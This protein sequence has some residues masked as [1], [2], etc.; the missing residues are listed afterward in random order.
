MSRGEN[1]GLATSGRTTPV[2]GNVSIVTFVAKTGGAAL[3]LIAKSDTA[4]PTQAMRAGRFQ[5]ELGMGT[6]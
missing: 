5:M 2:D 1:A 4:T 6:K 3:T